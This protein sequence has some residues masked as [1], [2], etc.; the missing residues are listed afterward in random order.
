LPKI[1][2]TRGAL[3]AKIE[4]ENAPIDTS[5]IRYKHKERESKRQRK[6]QAIQEEQ[7][8]FDR[9]GELMDENAT[10]RTGRS[11]KSMKSTRSTRTVMTNKSLGVRSIK[12]TK[13]MW[14]APE[15]YEAPED[16][17]N[18]AKKRTPQQRMADDW[19]DLAAEEQAYKKFKKGK[20]SKNEYDEFLLSEEAPELDVDT[21]L[22]V[23]EK[24]REQKR[25][26]EL[27]MRNGC[28]DDGNDDGG[29]GD[30][31]DSASV[32]SCG[33]MNEDDDEVA[34]GSSAEEG[35]ESDA[36]QNAS[37]DAQK[38]D[39]KLKTL[40]DKLLNKKPVKGRKHLGPKRV[41]KGANLNIP[42]FFQK[43]M[44]APMAKGGKNGKI[45]GANK[46]KMFEASASMQRKLNDMMTKKKKGGKGSQ[47]KDDSEG[48]GGRG[49][50][51]AKKKQ[52]PVP[53]SSKRGSHEKGKQFTRKF[54]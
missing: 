45:K 31:Y 11:G 37:R 43:K 14:V 48:R 50:R 25:K 47:K 32:A 36:I 7:E 2:E 52:K 10:Y 9:E 23:T 46:S 33:N 28:A 6:I 40:L 27:E 19:G 8:R 12:S 15:N 5:T 13:S 3:G 41:E 21:G 26:R 30:D 1:P 42:S 16:I 44:K 38:S 18:R 39:S 54:R 35:V 22:V 24:D 34:N 20:L 51:P 4:F 49:Q 53:G 17:R 29:D